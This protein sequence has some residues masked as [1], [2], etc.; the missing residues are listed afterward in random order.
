MWNPGVLL[1]A[2][3]SAVLILVKFGQAIHLL[4]VKVGYGRIRSWQLNVS[5]LSLVDTWCNYTVISDI[6]NFNHL[7]W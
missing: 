5:M 4:L 6:Y 7:E 3:E 2:R 1:T